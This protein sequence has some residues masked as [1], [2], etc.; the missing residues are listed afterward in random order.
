MSLEG[1]RRQEPLIKKLEQKKKT[2]PQNAVNQLKATLT[3][4]SQGLTAI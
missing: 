4:R 3:N 2:K 1:L